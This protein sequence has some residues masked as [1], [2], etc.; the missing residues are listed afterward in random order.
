MML[1][2]VIDNAA[3]EKSEK[4]LTWCVTKLFDCIL[5]FSKN[6]IRLLSKVAIE[7]MNR[8]A[9]AIHEHTLPLSKFKHII[10]I[11]GR[12]LSIFIQIVSQQHFSPFLSS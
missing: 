3:L 1:K 7:K 4:I 6:Q 12:I 8:N 5:K 10:T 9:Q 11:K 2:Y